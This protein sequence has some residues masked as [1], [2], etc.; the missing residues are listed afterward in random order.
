V[1]F[2]NDNRKENQQSFYVP[3]LRL[4]TWQMEVTNQMAKII[5]PVL[6]K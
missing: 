6:S 1:M 3:K 4:C 5:R 2:V